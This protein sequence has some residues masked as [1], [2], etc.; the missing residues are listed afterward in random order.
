[1]YITPLNSS[2]VTNASNSTSASEVKSVVTISSSNVY[3]LIQNISPQDMYLGIGFN[4]TATTGI[5]LTAGGGAV[6]YSGQFM[7]TGTY[8]LITAGPQTV[9]PFTCIYA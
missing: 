1:M 9:Q 4:P 7:P 5:L 2:G 8:N 3:I 6:E